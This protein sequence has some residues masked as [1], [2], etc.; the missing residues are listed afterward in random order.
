MV[1]IGSSRDAVR[2]AQALLVRHGASITPDGRFGPATQRA[3]IDFQRGAGL[4]PD[5]I[6]GPLTWR[7][8]ES[9]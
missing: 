4:S 8:L 5:G 6:V 9:T 3:V 7:A 2:D 1:R